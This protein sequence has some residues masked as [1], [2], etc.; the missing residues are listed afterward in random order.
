MAHM[1]QGTRKV[2]RWVTPSGRRWLVHRLLGD[3]AC[4][5]QFYFTERN[6][7]KSSDRSLAASCRFIQSHRAGGTEGSDTASQLEK[8]PGEKKSQ[9]YGPIRQSNIQSYYGLFPAMSLAF[10]PM[11]TH[12]IHGR[13][14]PSSFV[15][16]LWYHCPFG[17]SILSH[18][19]P[20]NPD[21]R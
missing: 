13:H 4:A 3:N 14:G 2:M 19:W 12:I 7:K 6:V 11:Q 5:L 17:P 18:N 9:Y 15:N 21:H 20:I 16:E 10:S 8:I 1:R